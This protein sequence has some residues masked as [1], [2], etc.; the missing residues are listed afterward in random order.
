MAL[1]LM[2]A[3]FALLSIVPMNRALDEAVRAA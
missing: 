3:V 2:P 1:G